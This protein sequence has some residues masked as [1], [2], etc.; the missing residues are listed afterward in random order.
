MKKLLNQPSKQVCDKM[1]STG[2]K[3]ANWLITIN[4]NWVEEWTLAS[5][6]SLEHTIRYHS[7]GSLF[8][9]GATNIVTFHFK[10]GSS[11]TMTEEYVRHLMY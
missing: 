5:Q 10:D 7:I 4:D 9:N 11:C 3:C 1:I 2:T 8:R 6:R